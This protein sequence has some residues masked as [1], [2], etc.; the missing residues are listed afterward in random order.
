M[1][2]LK[3][4][5]RGNVWRNNGLKISRLDENCEFTDP[6]AQEVP[7]TRNMRGNDLYQGTIKLL[8][9]SY[10]GNSNS[11]I[12]K[13]TLHIKEWRSDF[14]LETM[15]TRRHWNKILKELK[16]KNCKPRILYLISSK[17]EGEICSDIKKKK[18][19]NRSHYQ[20]IPHQKKC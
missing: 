17:N 14:S 10:K 12:E 16:E 2:S 9:I 11:A 1:E 8:K 6:R 7:S 13:N 4:R 15:Q 18:K 3:G 5:D 19:Q 20:Q